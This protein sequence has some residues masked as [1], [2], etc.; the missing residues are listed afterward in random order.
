MALSTLQFAELKFRTM[1]WLNAL[2][3]FATVITAVVA[4]FAYG[5]YRWTI[6]ARMRRIEDELSKKNKPNDDSLTVMQ[7]AI[8]LALTESQVIEAAAISKKVESWAGQSG[9]EYRFRTKRA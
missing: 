1:T 6:H 4:V 5:T 2:A 7:L 9:E 3:D 8:K